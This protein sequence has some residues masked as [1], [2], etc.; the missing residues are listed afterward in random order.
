MNLCVFNEFVDPH[1]PDSA[2]KKGSWGYSSRNPVP[3][4]APNARGPG[5]IP[6]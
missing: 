6:S 3:D 4:W 2:V 1:K 5:S